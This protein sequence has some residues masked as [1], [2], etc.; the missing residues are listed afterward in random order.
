MKILVSSDRV[1]VVEKCV[2][3]AKKIKEY[4]SRTQNF[5]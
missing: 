3:W 4:N 2:M 5:P 1:I